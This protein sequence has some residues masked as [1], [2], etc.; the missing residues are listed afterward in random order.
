MDGMVNSS[1]NVLV[2][3]NIPVGNGVFRK[4]IAREFEKSRSKWFFAAFSPVLIYNI[5][6]SADIMDKVN[7][8]RS[9]SHSM[10][11]LMSGLRD[12]M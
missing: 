11:R 5:G 9:L 8:L 12:L 3:T 10:P 1:F 6:K 4:Q 2:V 7:M